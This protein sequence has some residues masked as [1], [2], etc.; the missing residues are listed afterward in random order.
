MN[1]KITF[2][3]YNK[4]NNALPLGNGKM[5]AMVFFDDHKLHIALNDYDCYYPALGQYAENNTR[6]KRKT[7][8]ELCDR[9]DKARADGNAD[10]SHY[11]HTLYPASMES[12]PTYKGTSYPMA[13]EIVIPLC[14]SLRDFS[15]ELDIEAATVSF[16]AKNGDAIAGAKIWIPKT[17]HGIFV[18]FSGTDLWG[19]AEITKPADIGMS[20][21]KTESGADGSIKWLRT[22]LRDG[23]FIFETVF[24]LVEKF[25]QLKTKILVATVSPDGTRPLHESLLQKYDAFAMEHASQW[26]KF[27]RTSIRLPDYFL[28]TLWHLHIY[29]IE[30]ASGRGGKYIEQ[31]CGL[32]GLWDIRRPSLWGSMWYW[33]VNIQEAFW[34][35]FSANKLELGKLFCDGYLRYAESIAEYTKDVYG[36]EGWALDYPHTLYSCIQPW[37]AQF[38]W[39]YYRYS[40]DIEFLRQQA[41]PVFVKQIK[42]FAHIAQMGD[43]G[44]LHI[45]Y[46]ISPEQGP[47]SQDSVI[48]IATVKWLIKFTLEAAEIL[49]CPQTEKDEFNR[50]L[51]LLP[52][53]A[54]TECGTRFKDSALAQDNLFLRHPS[55][56]M[57]IF[58]AEELSRHS[59]EDMRRLAFNTLKFAAANTEMGVFGFGWLASAAAKMGEGTAALRILYEQ[60]IDNLI[61]TNGMG[62]EESER[63]IN[64]CLITKMPMYPPAMMEQSGGIVMAVNNMLMQAG[65]FIELFPALP[66]GVDNINTPLVQ[67]NQHREYMD[68]KYPAWDECEF[69]RMLAPGGFEV[70]A[71]KCDGK[72]AWVKIESLRGG[73]LKLMLPDGLVE[74]DMEAGEVWEWGIGSSLRG[75]KQSSGHY[76]QKQNRVDCFVGKSP[77][78]NDGQTLCHTA[79][80]T[81]RRIFLG[82][83]RHTAF[84]KSI[85]SFTCAYTMGNTR[86]YTMTPYVFDFTN[87]G[88]PKKNYDD[89]YRKNF[90][91]SGQA[92]VFFGAP[93]VCGANVYSPNLGYGFAKSKRL[94]ITD[95]SV[96]DSLRKDFVESAAYNEFLIELPRGKYNLLLISGDECEESQTN[97][98]TPHNGGRITGEIMPPGH[99]QSKVV[100]FMHEKDGIFRIILFSEVGRK[101]KLN[102]LFLSKEYVY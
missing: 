72:I 89:V 4:W 95:R 3:V 26:Q 84:Y 96:P 38:L 9:V 14:E 12:R 13:G 61:H 74:K 45:L 48:T 75:T 19:E 82:E 50:L 54:K 17:A 53:Y 70:S 24:Q 56:L 60:G 98:I 10:T 2:S 6:P 43:D 59:P 55:V 49:E 77:P 1:H 79:A 16:T 32:N 80:L 22:T 78:R 31:A 29:L 67:Y 46:D 102:A 66:N 100:P 86:Q 25:N 40:G 5:G 68:G 28:E 11:L 39:Q 52:E 7:Y 20:G 18:E 76:S 41:Y 85:D 88:Q 34:P 91:V 92:I 33:D 94:A 51:K 8:A 23:E 37:C 30:C 97:I 83:D 58:P 35:V 81:N 44:K 65:E 64:H 69:S 42:M 27:W 15:L 36:V 71:R 101:W 73:K 63:F 57:P 93:T 87:P 90:C 47:I 99:Y 62:Y 21:Y